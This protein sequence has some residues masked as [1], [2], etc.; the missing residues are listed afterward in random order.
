MRHAVSESMSMSAVR[1][2]EE[3]VGDTNG[4][5]MMM[6]CCCEKQKKNYKKAK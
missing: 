5:L 4:K 3:I 1:C 6:R 2:G